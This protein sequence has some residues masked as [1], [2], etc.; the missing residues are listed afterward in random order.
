MQAEGALSSS[1]DLRPFDWR[2][3]AAV[4]P[5][6]L[7]RIDTPVP[8]GTVWNA[9]RA[10]VFDSRINVTTGG[11]VH[12]PVVELSADHSDCYRLAFLDDGT[13]RGRTVLEPAAVGTGLV[14]RRV[15]VPPTATRA[16]YTRIRSSVESGDGMYSIGHVRLRTPSATTCG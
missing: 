7:D 10:V 14:T 8:D 4:R 13:V 6:P 1:V 12:C 15:T 2:P 9:D 5:S 16:G 11:R 3:P